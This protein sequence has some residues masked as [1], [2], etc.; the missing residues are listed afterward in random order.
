M[1][2]VVGVQVLSILTSI[3]KR[4][5]TNRLCEG[6]S[7]VIELETILQSYTLIFR[8][9]GSLIGKNANQLRVLRKRPTRRVFVKAAS[10]IHIRI[11]RGIDSIQHRASDKTRYYIRIELSESAIASVECTTTATDPAPEERENQREP[12]Q[13]GLN[14]LPNPLA[15]FAIG[16]LLPHERF[17]E[18]F[19]TVHKG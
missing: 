6:I 13:Y 11:R 9:H 4:V 10:H 15:V 8:L 17:E 14:L 1:V 18:R 7:H 19:G 5:G 12:L 3:T 2:D 16:T